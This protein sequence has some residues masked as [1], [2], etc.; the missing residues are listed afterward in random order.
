MEANDRFSKFI[1]ERLI[2]AREA[3][4]LTLAELADAIQ[5]SHQAISKY[6]KRR[7][8]PG[9]DVLERLSNALA[10]PVTYFYKKQADSQESVVYFRSMAM[11]TQK[12]KKVHF[13]KIRWIKEIHK[14]LE[15]YLE[16]PKINTPQFITRDTYIPIDFEEIERMASD[17][18]KM[19]NLG[20]GP[21]SDVV[22]LLEKSGIIVGRAPASSY[23][24][25]ACSKWEEGGNP[26]ILLSNDK[27]AVRSRFDI[28]H[29]LGHLV[30]HSKI[31]QSEFNK[32]ENYKQIEREAHY[33]AGAFLLP[34]SSFGTEI[35]STSIDHL[36]TLKKRW[37]VSIQAMAYR[38]KSLD[39]ISEYQHIN[40]RQRLAKN[41]QLSKEPLDDVLPFEEPSVL[42]QAIMALV[43][44][45]VKTRQDIV[46]EI[47]LPRE[48]IETFANLEEG[49][50]KVQDTSNVIRLNF[51]T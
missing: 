9:F 21:I 33:F 24:I 19:W 25:D 42:K 10:V 12:S 2:E 1:P 50:L 37:K 7:S 40:I 13:H 3:R 5:T 22:L 28:A 26:Y 6:E 15:Q 14:Y 20:N 8:V 46:S 4:G 29:E 43:D 39:I 23:K 45:K 47:C 11:A 32:K 27:T 38:A 41:N 51:R 31:K 49:Y 34:A 30:L 36:T 17:V 16:F 48:E 44:H 18:R 35:V